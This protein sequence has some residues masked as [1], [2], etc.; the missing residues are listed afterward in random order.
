M[1]MHACG[2]KSIPGR[3]AQM[4]TA[5]G[6]VTAVLLAMVVSGAPAGAAT[7]TPTYQVT[8]ILSGKSLHHWYYKAGSSK[9]HS[10]TL[11]DPDDI[12]RIGGYLF[13]GFQNGVGPQ[14]QASPD[15]NRDSTIVEYTLSGRVVNQWD[16]L[17]KCDGLT[18]DPYNGLV[19]ATVNE[20]AHSSLYTI[21]SFN[22]HVVHYAY[23]KPLPHNG[24]TDAIEFDNGLMLISASA[25]GTAGAAAPEPDYPAVY[26]TTLNPATR[27]ATVHALFYDESH[28]TAANGSHAG[29]P[30]KLGLTDPDSNEV[31]PYSS[32]RFAGYF[33][34]TS[35]GDQEQIYVYAPGTKKQHLWVLKLSQS[36]DDTAWATN[37]QGAL[38][39]ADTSG[40]TIDEVSGPSWPLGSAFV[41]VTPCDSNSAPA[42]CPAP[43]KYPANY[44]GRLNM[45]TGQIT[46]VS[47]RGP[48][49]EPQGM[50]FVPF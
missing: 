25:P 10:E 12:T 46:P 49:L 24:G 21:D 15:G 20:D 6:A 41:A 4:L 35:Q 37:W 2:S 23:N 16:V 17:G 50:I 36:V 26:V 11:A 33:M 5:L 13:S 34:L 18:A 27:V 31:V 14:G 29:H 45:S 47:P 1:M 40:D 43:P 32:A 42:T 9:R 8:Q 48:R 44:L 22:S 19:V 3:A 38:Y 7:A 30:V 39:A 28:A